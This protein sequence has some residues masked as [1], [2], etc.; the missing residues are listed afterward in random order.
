MPA[1]RVELT[2]LHALLT[3]VL[4]IYRGTTGEVELRPA[5]PTRCR[6]CS[7]IRRRSTRSFATWSTTRSRRWAVTVAST[8]RPHHLAAENRVRIVVA[9]DGPGI[10]A[11]E[12]DK[13]F[14]SHYST[15]QRGSGLGLAIVRRIV[16]EHGGRIE[17]TDNAPRGTGSH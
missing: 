7:S 17:V 16:D 12:R 9:D 5:S 3:D 1:P 13:L 2:D 4:T 11:A 14:L 15:K 6:R 10:P 8:S